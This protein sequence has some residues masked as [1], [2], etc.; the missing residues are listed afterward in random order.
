MGVE[1]V[2]GTSIPFSDVDADAWYAP[3]IRTATSLSIVSGYEDGTFQP[4]LVVTRVEGLKI[5]LNAKGITLPSV[6]QSHYS[7]VDQSAW[8][9]PYVQYVTDHT[10]L[11]VPGG[12]FG[13]NEGLRRKD[14][15]QILF[16]MEEE[17]Q[18]QTLPVFPIGMVSMLLLL[19]CVPGLVVLYIQ[20]TDCT[21]PMHMAVQALWV[22]S[23]PLG[24]L[25]TQAMRLSTPHII[26]KTQDA[27]VLDTATYGTFR[28]AKKRYTYFRRPRRLATELISWLDANGKQIMIM[29]SAG[30]ALYFMFL[31][32]GTSIST[33]R[34]SAS[35]TTPEY[36]QNSANI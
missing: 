16:R 26:S 35:F 27:E 5:L 11:E 13:V 8:Y 30:I 29:L 9:V 22:L 36:D 23:G 33:Y 20:R 25:W 17:K 10:L 6:R 12:I 1:P 32:I 18:A 2:E 21:K 28:F 4:D 15:A 31:I 3:Y 24:L 14:I 7:D 19:I 34:Y